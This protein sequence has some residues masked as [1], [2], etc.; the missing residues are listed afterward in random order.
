MRIAVAGM[1]AALVSLAAALAP[2]AGRVISGWG[3]GEDLAPY[4][5]AVAPHAPAMIAFEAAV[6]SNAAAPFLNAYR[7]FAT[8]HGFFIA[9]VSLSFRGNEHDVATGMRDPD[10][11]V[12]ADGLR[13][14]KMPVLL[15]IGRDFNEPGAPYA[16]SGYIGAFRHT[17]EVFHREIPN[18]AA[19]WEA[20]ARGVSDPSYMKWYPGDD[21]VDWW[22][23]DF[24][25]A[26]DFGSAE[27]K[28]FL[29][30]ATQHRKPLM[31]NATEHNLKSDAGALKW[32][33]S[34]FDFVRANPVVAAVS[35]GI[36]THQLEWPKATAYLKQ[37]LA[38]PR[39]IDANEAPAIFHPR[40]TEP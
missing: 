22:G 12:I 20:T 25:D 4:S 34:V 24:G 26:K 19:V 28:A 16:T 5:K 30:E 35:F 33:R 31:I 17:T 7:A 32:Y 13:D 23:I 6:D 8:S 15:S 14:V 2:P 9:Q 29:D 39:F 11:Y 18:F 38:D 36:G 10:L 27:S 3:S 37:Q 21:V 40:R 1:L